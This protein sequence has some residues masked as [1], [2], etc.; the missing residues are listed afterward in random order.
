MKVKTHNKRISASIQPRKMRNYQLIYRVDG[1]RFERS[2]ETK[3]L[4]TAKIKAEKMLHQVEI[5]M[6]SGIRLS[7]MKD[8]WFKYNSTKSKWYKKDIE[9]HFQPFIDY[10]NNCYGESLTIKHLYDYRSH[11]ES[12]MSK[13][14]NKPL[15]PTSIA[16]ALGTIKSVWY[17]NRK[18]E[19]IS[20]DI[21]LNFKLPKKLERKEWLTVEQLKKVIKKADD[22][23]LYQGFIELVIINGL[24]LGE[25]YKLK[26]S[27][28][29]D[30]RMVLEKT[31]RGEDDIVRMRDD[32]R[33]ALNKI[34]KN[35]R[36]HKTY[37][38]SSSN[39]ERLS[40]SS[41][42]K[43]IKRYLIL[44]GFPNH[45][46]HS[47]RHSYATNLII[48]GTDI[49]RVKE[50][51]R[52][53]S[54]TTTQKYIKFTGMDISEVEARI[55]PKEEEPIQYIEVD[56]DWKVGKVTIKKLKKIVK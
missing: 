15:S 2:L 9:K 8:E 51:M 6:I 31:K 44:A 41:C 55:I 37:I 46:P 4:E 32:I 12:R 7:E 28:I 14:N 10:F 20:N 29:Y 34:H 33:E 23:P 1:K 39:G 24:R 43:I 17:F 25:L 47:L 27:N 40:Y 53:N 11:L 35:Q 56:T 54:V 38:C 21:F 3:D 26:W 36:I 45:T 5:E 48:M 50:L 19:N 49:Y 16:I 42:H 30:N 52:H 18:L 22:N 13:R